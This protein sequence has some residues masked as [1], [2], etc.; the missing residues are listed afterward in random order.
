MLLDTP[1]RKSYSTK[2]LSRTFVER[3]QMCGIC[4]FVITAVMSN[5]LEKAIGFSRL[6]MA[7]LECY[8]AGRDV[9]LRYRRI[10]LVMRQLQ[11]ASHD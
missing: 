7:G 11:A 3:M 2:R 9:I 4:G 10:N 5:L 1:G 6:V 8:S